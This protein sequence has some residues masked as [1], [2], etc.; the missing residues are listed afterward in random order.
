MPYLLDF[1]EYFD[2][3]AKALAKDR[4]YVLRPNA[5]NPYKQLY[6]QS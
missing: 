6:T 2:L 5:K 3:D 4:F 1:A